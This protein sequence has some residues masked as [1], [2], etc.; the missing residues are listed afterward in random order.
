MIKYR[1]WSAHAYRDCH[2]ETCCCG[3]DEYVVVELKKGDFYYAT[4]G[5]KSYCEQWVKD[6]DN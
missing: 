2:P 4:S 5:T 6:N 3:S 1:I